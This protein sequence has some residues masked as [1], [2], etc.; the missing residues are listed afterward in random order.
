[1]PLKQ[2]FGFVG[3]GLLALI[4]G[5]NWCITETPTERIRSGASKSLIR[6]S[7]IER[8]PERVVFDT[9]VPQIEPQ[10]VRAPNNLHSYSLK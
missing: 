5:L 7:S 8:L 9:S 2:Y 3:S 4:F 10:E 6:V 1:M